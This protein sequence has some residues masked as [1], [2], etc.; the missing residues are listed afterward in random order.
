MIKTRLRYK[1]LLG[2][3]LLVLTVSAAITAVVSGIVIRQNKAAVHVSLDKALSLVRDSLVDKQAGMLEKIRQMANLQKLG[4]NVKFIVDFKD[5][6]TSLTRNSYETAANALAGIAL[7]EELYSARL[8]SYEGELVAYFETKTEK[9]LVT[10]FLNAG[11]FYHRQFAPGEPHDQI[12]MTESKSIDG[13]TLLPNYGAVIPEKESLDFDVKDGHV[14]LKTIVP[15]YSNLYNQ[16]TEQLEAVQVGFVVA[17][18]QLKEEFVQQM[19]RI[20]GMEMNLFVGKTFSA[21]DFPSYKSVD[22]N[23]I[24]Q[25]QPKGVEADGFYF[26][27]IALDQG[28][29]FQALIPFY[30]E[31]K[32]IGG[33][34][35]LQSDAIVKANT[36]QM[37]LMVA[38]VALV[39]VFLVLPLAWFAAGRVVTPLLDIVNK[40]RDIAEGQGD[41]TTRLEVKSMDEIGQ[42]ARW[43]NSFIDK[44]HALVTDVA[45][46]A[47]TLNNSST[48]LAQVS[49]VMFDAADQT[50]NKSNSVSAA[51][52]EMSMSMDSVA[53]AMEDA[54]ANMGMVSAATDEMSSTIGEISN[55]T[56]EAR[57]ITQ[58][59]VEK[60][61]AASDRVEELGASAEEIGFVVGTITDISDQVNLLALNATIEAARAGE[62]GK[63]F[64]VVANE[65][66]VLANQTANATR[67][68]EEKVENIKNS[69]GRTV[70]EIN[71]VSDVAN[72]VNEIVVIIASAV[73]EQSVTTRNIA[74]NIGQVTLA[75]DK[76]NDNISQSSSVSKEISMDLTGVTQA[77]E[78]MN[79]HSVTVETKS[80][81]LSDLS[82]ILMTL[83]KKFKI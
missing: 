60:T 33:L 29:F 32:S 65:I 82:E 79:G 26:S 53:K 49:K 25:S 48:D 12:V 23:Q 39:C 63:G 64:A 16:K 43:F 4:D 80:R 59:V 54:S 75:I 30:S 83:V 1:I 24:P 35:I 68:I 56:L 50:S 51:S 42:V 19:D 62:A 46:N 57:Q 41:L 52:E 76:I 81:D 45:G 6:G 66:K 72:K 38:L 18:K 44:I 47:E 69:T 22:L 20:T 71:N 55:N 70:E 58:D 11:T 78:K 37:V 31:G 77:A 40:L 34:L 61:R 14:S 9:D 2:A 73:E 28:N 3:L 74:K 8:Y 15:F 17:I 36:R 21:G 27:D 13:V 67:Q 10:G 5:Q 7:T